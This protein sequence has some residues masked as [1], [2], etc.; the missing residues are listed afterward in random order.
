MTLDDEHLERTEAMRRIRPMGI[1]HGISQGL[2]G[3]GINLLGAVSGIAR[4]AL[5]AKSSVEVF[6]GLGKGI[7]GVVAKPISG[8]AEFLAL[9]G[10]GVLQTVGFNAMPLPR[11]TKTLDER[12]QTLISITKATWEISTN[13]LENDTVLAVAPVVY[14]DKASNLNATIAITQQHIYI[15]HWL[16]N[17]L[18]S[19]ILSMDAI[20]VSIDPNNS[21]H[22]ILS[23]KIK[24][25]S[26]QLNRKRILQYLSKTHVQTA[27]SRLYLDEEIQSST[28][29]NHERHTLKCENAQVASY[30]EHYIQFLCYAAYTSAPT[31]HIES[32]DIS[33]NPIE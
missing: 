11:D 12:K 18:L 2:T 21:A 29:T 26:Q 31:Q 3:F 16:E 1:T 8:A 19:I 14:L 24:C 28:V 23:D 13:V 27:E 5:E 7:I 32:K 10:Q 6:T 33:Q 15:S 30:L 4:H 17:S 20:R 9:T 22:L 25:N